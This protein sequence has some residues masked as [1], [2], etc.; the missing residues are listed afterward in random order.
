[1][2]GLHNP[3]RKLHRIGADMPIVA[4]PLGPGLTNHTRCVDSLLPGASM[5]VVLRQKRVVCFVQYVGYCEPPHTDIKVN[6]AVCYV[7]YNELGSY[8]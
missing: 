8:K 1:M 2:A 4:P 5:K 6:F 3:M 7:I